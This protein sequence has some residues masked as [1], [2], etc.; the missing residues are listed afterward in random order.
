MHFKD[1]IV[2]ITGASSGI[3]KEVAIQMSNLG[4]ILILTSSNEEKLI[5]VQNE[6]STKSNK[7]YV[8]PFDL[9]NIEG[10]DE[11]AQKAIALEGRIDCVIQSA[12]ISQRAT[13][14]QTD[15]LV[16][17]KLM[18][19]NYFA[20]VALSQAVL[21]HFK[22]HNAGNMVVI[23]SI[24]GLIGFPLRS[25]YAASKHAVKG[26]FE[27][28]QTELYDSNITIS[29]V[30]PGRIDTNIS[31]NAITGD[32]SKAEVEDANNKVGM[33]VSECVSQLIKGLKSN[34]K[35]IYIGKPE[36]LLFWIWWFFPSLYLKI[37][38]KTGLKK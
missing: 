22:K 9:F 10:I 32:G 2:W 30:Y 26:Y 1:K 5:E 38:H 19:I 13:A 35:A 14:E 3:G 27:T 37:S 29:I 4:A 11:L 21:P 34:K 28:L 31:R 8:L 20:T 15:F 17:K 25:G 16:Y 33:N 18:E 6:L 7:S 36:R 12:G 23:S 24:A